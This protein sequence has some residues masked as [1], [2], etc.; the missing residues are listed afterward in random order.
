MVGDK[1]LNISIAIVDNKIL[2]KCLNSPRTIVIN[3]MINL[4]EDV[5]YRN[6]YNELKDIHPLGKE[7]EHDSPR[8]IG[9]IWTKVARHD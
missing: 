7:I 5:E 8:Q 6:K 2:V 4:K 9:A 3:G 1:F